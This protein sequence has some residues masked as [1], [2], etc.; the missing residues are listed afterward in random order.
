MKLPKHDP[1]AATAPHHGGSTIRLSLTGLIILCVSMIATSSLITHL[2]GF[3]LTGEKAGDPPA[4]Q[5]AS[6]AGETESHGTVGPWGELVTLDVDI[7][8]PLE[9]VSF[10]ATTNRVTTW[11][12]PGTTVNQARDLMLASGFTEAQVTGALSPDK[13]TDT[14]EAIIV[15]PDDALVLALSPEVRCKF[16]TVLAAWPENKLM[17]EPYHLEEKRFEALFIKNDVDP[18]V[19]KLVGKLAYKRANNCYFSDL[20][21]V[22]HTI[23]SEDM[24]VNLLKALTSQVAVLAR[25]RVRPDS[26][27]DKILGYWTTVPGVRA[28]DLRPL[29]ESIK[30]VPD[31][32]TISLLYFLPKFA[33]E[34]L[35][36]FPMPT[37]PGDVKMDCHWTALNFLNEIPD[38]KLQDNAYASK[39]IETSFY[40]IGKASMCGDLIFLLDGKGA[41]IHSAV[42]IADDLVFTK[43]G[44]NYAQPWILMRI[45]TL[46]GVYTCTAEPKVLYYRRKEA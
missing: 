31:G 45:K 6:K 37:K 2:M 11:T 7:E 21:V 26:D 46:L 15:K 9:Y 5:V 44:I 12:F 40:Q 34:R 1:R 25:L 23:R 42:Y 14:P 32:G 8:Q 19:V 38:D 39:Y 28:K 18:E 16:Y 41:V 36:T 29:L 27:L 30:E 24:R 13:M 17:R 3:H 22:L 43:N 4:A 35:Y 10:E 20:E 33:R